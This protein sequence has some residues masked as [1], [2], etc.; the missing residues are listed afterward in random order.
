[1][2]ESQ[3]AEESLRHL[4]EI[5]TR[6]KEEQE[7]LLLNILEKNRDTVF[8]KKYGFDRIR[9]VSDF[10]KAVP[11]TAFEDYE[12]LIN[13]EIAGERGVFTAD[14]PYFYC[15][16]SG[17][18]GTV[19]YFPLTRED[20]VLQHRYWDGAIRAIIRRDLS[21]YS[22]EELFGK[23]FL[24]SDAYLTNMPDGI[25]NG[26][27]SGVASRMQQEDG[28]YPYELF[29]A[30]E[31]V[32]FPKTLCDMQYVKFRF[33][34]EQPDITA[35]HAN[36]V[37]KCTAMLRFLE[38]HWD[39]FLHDMETGDV[40]PE[41]K[42]DEEWKDY[43]KRNL[44]PN[45]KRA[46]ELRRLSGPD[47]SD[48]LIRKIWPNVKYLRL[49]SG[50]QFH[51]YI[52]ILDHYSGSLPVYPFLFA[53]SEGMFCVAAGVGR[54]DEYIMIPDLCFFEFLPEQDENG[55]CLTLT[56]LK[57][58]E[59]YE[60]VITTVSG[61]YRYRL[62]DVIE[63]HGFYENSPIISINY[64][65]SQILNLADEKM[66]STQFEGAISNFLDE[67]G[68]RAIGYC[69]SAC[70]EKD[71]PCYRVFLEAKGAPP[72]EPSFLMDQKLCENCFGYRGAREAEELS[73][74][75]LIFLPPNTFEEYERLGT[76]TGKRNEQ[77]K[78]LKI[79]TSQE[80]IDF[81]KRKG[82]L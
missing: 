32:L 24:M 55:P 52:E 1:M 45:P 48:G 63:V 75:E 40:S 18:M 46:E 39:A 50:M 7:K 4:N 33:A 60:I 25:M 62:G 77:T 35:I 54:M 68:M 3:F 10:Q 14:P 29:Y 72:K 13:R 38:R 67:S 12:P 56:Q 9:S 61:L 22:E 42:V 80:Q 8:G 47:L 37:H 73:E 64:R 69:V 34:L 81:F 82:R 57:E 49:S 41:F 20:A 58:G 53:A 27:R 59:K 11:F 43:L 79:I 16:S 70:R 17:S 6:P 78:P 23:I 19:K 31:E 21:Q 65:K 76:G 71:P 30:P 51:P 36:F 5:V 15:I 26:V 28:T 44:K 74:A 66:N 2:I